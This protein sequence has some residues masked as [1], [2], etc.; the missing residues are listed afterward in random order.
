[1]FKWPFP[2]SNC[3]GTSIFCP[4]LPWNVLCNLSMVRGICD[5]NMLKSSEKH[6]NKRDLFLHVGLPGRLPDCHLDRWKTLA[7][8][9]AESN[10]WEVGLPSL[11]SP[12]RASSQSSFYNWCWLQRAMVGWGRLL[13]GGG[14]SAH[15]ILWLLMALA[16]LVTTLV[17]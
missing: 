12:D 16:F 10:G 8:V 17:T 14:H 1:M 9:R 11:R 4:T 2:F 3:H 15:G 7:E 13:R 5:E 6:S